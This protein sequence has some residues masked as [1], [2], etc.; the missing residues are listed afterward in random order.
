MTTHLTATSRLALAT[1]S[2]LAATLA[3]PGAWAQNLPISTAQKQTAQEVAQKGVPL[4][5]LA[6]N[7]PERYTVK[8]GDTLWDISKM[9]LKSPWRW[10]ELWGMNLSDIKNPHRIYPGQV[11]V[12]VR[13]GESAILRVDGSDDSNAL[14]T[15]R[16]SPRTRSESLSDL[17]LA[18]VNSK[19]IAPFLAEP[20]IVGAAELQAAPRI[21]ATP[22][23]RILLS[24]G[25]RAYVRGPD[26]LPLQDIQARTRVFRLFREAVPMKDPSSGEILGYEAQYV[27]KAALVRGESTSEEE[28][29]DGKLN[30]LVVPASIDVVA[31]KQ[32]VRVGD[33]LLPEPQSVNYN[34]TPH[35]P[36]T[37]VEA[38]IISIYGSTA[39]NAGQSQ[40][41]SINR[42]TQ[43]GMDAG[44]VLAI[45]KNGARVKD[46]TVEGTS[47]LKL[48]D[49]RNGLLM[50]FRTFDRVSYALILDVNDSVRA[51]DRLVNPR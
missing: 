51:G 19:V 42:G 36:S 32:E 8:S 24:R 39:I 46:T 40:V 1:A 12:L 43:D 49:E 23:S 11:L 38:R 7:A 44:Q 3:A 34:F 50:V 30:T 33:R 4:S 41:V 45:L 16:V 10:P 15:V 48:P 25:D 22:E 29:E 37:R 13:M 18:A 21:V 20:L 31:A 9:F 26:G 47:M 35:A 28:G 14:D 5:E 6:S 27:G 2:M 17:A